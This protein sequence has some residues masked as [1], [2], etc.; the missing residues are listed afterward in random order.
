MSSITLPKKQHKILSLCPKI[1]LFSPD[2][3]FSCK[4]R[5]QKIQMHPPNT[6]DHP[7]NASPEGIALAERCRQARNRDGGNSL[8]YINRKEN[9]KA[10][11]H[12]PCGCK[13][14]SPSHAASVFHCRRQFHAQQ[15]HFARSTGTNFTEKVLARARAFSMSMGDG[16][17]IPSYFINCVSESSCGL[18]R[19][20]CIRYTA[21][22]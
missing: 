5:D 14:I 10:P 15:A 16:K 13:K 21:I 6:S 8:S 2:R 19:A 17:T 22:S 7:G 18:L 3:I 1:D 4:S 11:Q 20:H 9:V 12:T